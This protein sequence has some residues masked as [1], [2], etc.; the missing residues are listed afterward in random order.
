MAVRAVYL[1]LGA[2]LLALAA[3][4][5]SIAVVLLLLRS[6]PG[7]V[8]NATVAVA[9]ASAGA[10][11]AA[12]TGGRIPTP[13]DPGFPSPPNGAIVL[14]REA[15]SDALGFALLPDR[16][17]SL[18][19]VSVINGAGSG[20]AGLRVSV[21]FGARRPLTLSA[22]GAGCYQR[23]VTP[24]P[25]RAV[26]IRLN[27]T[28]YTLEL[29]AAREPP[30]GSAVVTNAARVWRGLTSLVWHER[31]ASSATNV[32]E[33]TY[34]AV[35]PD[36][37]S[38]T[39]A[40]QSAAVI[41]GETRW[42]RPSP[43]GGWV[44]SSQ[45]PPVHVPVPFWYGVTDARVLASGHV[46][47]RAVWSVSFFDPTTPAWFTA[48]IDKQNGRTLELTMIAAGH[49]MHHRYLSFNTPIHLRPPTS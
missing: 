5:V 27:A 24:V 48:E 16:S 32:L 14:A 37:L 34:E 9:A 47:P 10:A 33:T 49:F 15:G 23:T 2:A 44:R 19:R 26:S 6:E 36:E 11:S 30:D 13:T 45:I 3:G 42:D 28:A 22:C 17:R 1:R 31:L 40:G 43:T 20:A 12:P 35:A 41:I 4:A 21:A 29:P 8:A 7:P 25:T 46:G 38:Y 39:I 18:V